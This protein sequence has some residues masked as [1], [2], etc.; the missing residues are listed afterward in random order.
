[1]RSLREIQ[2]CPPDPLPQ[3]YP[4]TLKALEGFSSMALSAPVTFLVGDNGSGKSTFLEA[5]A[6]AAGLQVEGGSASM[7]VDASHTNTDLSAALRLVWRVKSHQG[8]FFRAETLYNLASYLDDMAKEP[9]SGGPETVFRA[10]G[11]RSLHHRS[12]GESFLSLFQHRL[13]PDRPALYLFDEPESALSITAQL[14]FLRL[15]K[16]WD[17]SGHIQMIIAT[18]SPIILA[19]PGAAIWDF[20]E[21]PMRVTT[22]QATRP[23]QLTRSFLEAPERFLQAL[24]EDDSDER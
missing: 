3:R 9:F 12:H 5:L 20:D 6:H 23:Y 10:Y 22:Y 13:N 24:F 17:T 15:L 8:F 11:G 21:H 14:A 4:Y 7:L 19:Y 1:M 2:Y 18:H 16:T